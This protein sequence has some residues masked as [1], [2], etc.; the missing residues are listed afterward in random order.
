MKELIDNLRQQKFF[1]TIYD[2]GVNK[3]DFVLAVIVDDPI[4]IWYLSRVMSDVGVPMLDGRLLYFPDMKINA[5]T[6]EY[7][8]A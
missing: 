5:E 6:Y 7:I 2:M 3:L 4:E 8:C 1:P